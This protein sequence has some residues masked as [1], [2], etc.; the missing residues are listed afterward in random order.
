[1]IRASELGEF[2]FCRRAWWLRRVAELEPD[3]LLV[4]ER[5]AAAHADHSRAVS[6]SQALLLLAV[7]LGLVALLLIVSGT[8]MG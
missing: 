2:M 5:G 6:G 4:L 1:M 3:N 7:A 8:F